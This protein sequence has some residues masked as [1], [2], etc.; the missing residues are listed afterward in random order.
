MRHLLKNAWVRLAGLMPGEIHRS[1]FVWLLQPRSHFP[2][3]TRRRAGMVINR[4]RLFAFLFAVLT[5]LWSLV[6]YFFFPSSLWLSLAVLRL[7]AGFG[8]YLLVIF[9]KPS[10]NIKTAYRRIALLFLIPT[11]FYL[12]SHQLLGSYELTGFSAAI[13]AGY[14]FLPF[15]LLTGMA[16]FPLTLIENIVIALPV[17][18]AQAL[19]S[20][21]HLGT[22]DAMPLAGTFWLLFLIAGVATL[23]GLSQLTFMI[24]IV[25]QAIRDPLTGAYSRRS[26][27]ETMELQFSL[28]ERMH[29]PLS[30]AFIDLDHFKSINDEYGH[31]AGDRALIAMSAWIESSLRRGDVLARWGGEEFVLI[32]PNTNL[33]QA[34]CALKRIREV[35]FGKRP[36]GVT[37]LTASIGVSEK[38]ADGA[39]DWQQL[40][41]IAD[42]RMYIAKKSGRDR[43]ESN[44]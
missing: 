21:L 36:D 32:L 6:D 15:V 4:V 40:V 22:Q 20:Y 19:S 3:L 35:G 8:F 14:A 34:E 28:A 31:D 11:L 30:V 10:G 12:T 27:Q 44:G 7:I 43:V 33:A 5:P 18:L 39:L 38:Q 1:E 29:T 26:G 25:Q 17:L 2:L 41:E 9:C 16:V 42:R 37:P 23:S 24:A 13:G